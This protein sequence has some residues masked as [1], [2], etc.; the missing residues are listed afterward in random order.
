MDSIL[1]EQRLKSELSHLRE[2]QLL[3][4]IGDYA[5]TDSPVMREVMERIVTVAPTRTTVL[6][7]GETGTGKG[8]ASKLIHLLSNRAKKPFISVHCGAI[9]DTLLESELFGHEKGA[10]TGAIRRK[11]GKFQLAHGGTIF[12]DELST[13]SASA[14]IKLLQVLQEKTFSMVGGDVDI[15]VDVRIVGASNSDLNEICEK[16]TFRRDLYYRL[17]VFPIEMPPLRDRIEDI[18]LLI[19]S[20]LKALNR[21][22]EKNITGVDEEVL[23]ALKHYSWPGNIREL[24]NV[25]ERAYILEKSNTLSWSGFPME[26]VT[27]RPVQP[28]T[29]SGSR[30]TLA[31]VRLRAV[32]QAEALYLQEILSLS[33]G[34]IDRSASMAGVTARQLYNLMA[35]YGIRKEKFKG[36]SN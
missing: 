30:P 21:E 12:L 15:S 27:F 3:S 24:E 36:Q 2:K 16:G 26:I 34:R 25:I 31:D 7:I 22:Y 20:F 19:D 11:I 18:P 33:S 8:V 17:S 10:F 4:D 23:E 1:E 35:K 28:G 13:L 9:P 32:E 5:R 29:G 14:Q 6:L